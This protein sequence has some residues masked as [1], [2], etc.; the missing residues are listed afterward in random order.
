MSGEINLSRLISSMNPTVSEKQ[1]VFVSVVRQHLSDYLFLAP[2][3]M[4][5]EKEGTTLIVEQN[6]ADEANINYA[7]SYACITLNVHSSLEA[8][9]L[10]AAVS[11]QLAKADISANVVAAYYHDHIF[12]PSIDAQKALS[13]L[14]QLIELSAT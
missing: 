14:K 13:A 10:T 3:G 1:Y 2:L 5:Q 7:G 6:K 11:T 9:G 8:V 12:V 4:F